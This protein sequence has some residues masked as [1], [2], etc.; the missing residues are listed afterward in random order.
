MATDTQTTTVLLDEA[1][2]IVE[3]EWMRLEQ[4]EDLWREV[5]DVFAEMPAPRSHPPRASVATSQLRRSGPPRPDTLR[6][7]PRRRR[8]AMRVWATQRSPPPD[9]GVVLNGEWRHLQG[10]QCAT[11]LQRPGGPPVGSLA[12]LPAARALLPRAPVVVTG[13]CPASPS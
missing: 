6:R 12:H 4:D 11:S 10:G 13:R 2:A 1:A 8:P 7:W 9:L 3:A 5:G